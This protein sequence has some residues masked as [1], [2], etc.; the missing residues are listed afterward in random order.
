MKTLGQSLYRSCQKTSFKL[1][2]NLGNR[3]QCQE[4]RIGIGINKEDTTLLN[5]KAMAIHSI[6]FGLY[7]LASAI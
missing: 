4:P 6:S 1:K 3:K 5:L 7:M 2:G